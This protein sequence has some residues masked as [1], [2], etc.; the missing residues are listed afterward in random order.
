VIAL[1]QTY[2]DALR[3]G[4]GHSVPLAPDAWRIE[5]GHEVGDSGPR[6][7]EMLIAMSAGEHALILGID[8]LRWYVDGE[9]AV[10]IYRLELDAA[11]VGL[12]VPGPVHLPVVERFRVH[13]GLITEVE[14]V[15]P[16]LEAIP[17]S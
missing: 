14:P 6:I 13:A 5:N 7:Q 16:A 10:A 12:D 9:E 4:D 2:V 3:T 15:F 8:D 17:G 1:C 11:A